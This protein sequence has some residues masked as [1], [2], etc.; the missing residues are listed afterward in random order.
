[1]TGH[2]TH[3]DQKLRGLN[4]PPPERELNPTR[5]DKSSGQLERIKSQE[6]KSRSIPTTKMLKVLCLMRVQKILLQ[7]K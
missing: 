4:A 7:I 5:L 3:P 1:M 6:C 2:H